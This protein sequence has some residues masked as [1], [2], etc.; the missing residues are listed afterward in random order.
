V[1]I[2]A[3]EDHIWC[4]LRSST[5]GQV[6]PVYHHVFEWPSPP[7]TLIQRNPRLS[8]QTGWRRRHQW[9][10][11]P[12]VED[13]IESLSHE[14]SSTRLS[15][16]KD[17]DAPSRG[18][19]D[20]LP[21]ILDA[22][23]T[24]QPVQE[25][26]RNTR[27]NYDHGSA[28]SNSSVESLGPPTPPDT[29]QDRRYVYIP[30]DGVE[31]PITY[32]ND[33]LKAKGTKA[34][35]SK[36]PKDREESRGRQS[37]PK[38]DTDLGADLQNLDGSRRR[39]P[40][41]YAYVRP[42]KTNRMSGE[43]FLSPDAATPGPR[44]P[45]PNID[46][47]RASSARPVPV[48][49]HDSSDSSDSGRRP[50][51]RRKSSR[52]SSTQHER[53]SLGQLNDR[54]KS[55]LDQRSASYSFPKRDNVEPPKKSLLSDR[56]RLDSR[57]SKPISPYQ[58]SDE[59][60]KSRLNV[61]DTRGGTRSARPSF[62]R[63]ERP[64][65]DTVDPRR[66]YDTNSPTSTRDHHRKHRPHLDE[67]RHHSSY[68][69]RGHP[70]PSSFK[71]P[72]AMEDY[73]EKAFQQNRSKR[74]AS[75]RSSPNPSPLASPART[76]PR[77]PINNNFLP[78]SGSRRGDKGDMK[79][80]TPMTPMTNSAKS[81]ADMLPLGRTDT[82]PA[83][84]TSRHSSALSSPI[85]ERRMEPRLSVQAPSPMMRT[86]PGHSSGD[87]RDPRRSSTLP[88][89]PRPF[90]LK[91]PPPARPFHSN[92]VS[93]ATVPQVPLA[94]PQKPPNPLILAPCA[95]P[96]PIAGYHDWYTVK[97]F[98]HLDFCP[99]CMGQIGGSKFRNVFIPSL[100]KPSGQEVQCALGLPWMRMAWIQTIKQRRENL[101]LLYRIHDLGETA[102][103]CSGKKG[104]IRSWYR[105]HHPGTG[106][107]VP[108]FD[109]CSACVRSVEILMPELRGIF[110]RSGGLVQ[111]RTCDL[112]C[113]S[114]RFASYLD[115]LDAAATR[116]FDEDRDPDMR[117]FA[118]HARRTAATRECC[119][120]DF[121]LGKP[122]H[123]HPLLPEF[124]ICEECFDEV[125]Y[126]LS[127]A[128]IAA[129]IDPNPHPVG[130]RD[131]GTSCQLYSARMRKIFRDAV[132]SNDFGYLKAEALRRHKVE[133]LLQERYALLMREYPSE[134]RAE[135]LKKNVEEW[136]KW[137]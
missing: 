13:E 21:I 44:F 30:H 135:D 79:P 99:G 113:D 75:P 71:N 20:Q 32:S 91:Q 77:S 95:R 29:N 57:N 59:S 83:A 19:V 25:K 132:K 106:N 85:E 39:A 111:E 33:N 14:F 104:A 90:D 48:R 45:L 64:P 27:R 134:R 36:A 102:K 67:S 18:S 17:D 43:F 2:P 107:P 5:T 97:G 3:F 62:S 94:Q 133:R 10:P 103:P 4:I 127:S 122:W 137:E 112:R 131:R 47:K 80:L 89:T 53:P 70:E 7:H 114:K 61:V 101:N 108:N 49:E 69:G 98:P 22:F 118:E 8:M 125:V 73:F 65:L 88:H 50:P 126:P 40:S 128:P 11:R 38:L 68:D 63:P 136:R 87:E 78:I 6:T 34:E 84:R 66:S 41:P 117:A 51:E 26:K 109:A 124:T 110:K 58:S 42:E 56:P 31:I 52:Y 28:K 130:P 81:S 116:A 60:T 86:S 16:R 12:T 119:K 74:T 76:P 15:Q 54:P 129:R 1:S 37:V 46:A 55:S 24:Q 9:P 35:S 123:I 120:D 93:L 105:V 100:P 72:K 92:P 23:P 82:F 96:T 121:V 115:L